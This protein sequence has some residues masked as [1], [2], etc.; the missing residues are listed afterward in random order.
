MMNHIF[1]KARFEQ[2]S[3]FSNVMM[4]GSDIDYF[5]EVADKA[6]I[7]V[8]WKCAGQELPRGQE[9]GFRR[10]VSDLGQVKPSFLVVAEH[11]T[12]PDDAIHG[13]NSK[14]VRV[15]YRLPNMHAPG[16]YL[17]DGQLPSLNQ[18]LSD[19]TLE[20]QIPHR[21]NRNTLHPWEG[22][23]GPML[24]SEDEANGYEYLEDIPRMY[25][26][27]SEFFDHLRPVKDA[28]TGA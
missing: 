14:V 17:Y 7:A 4:W 16:Q 27:P 13:D 28:Y 8:E 24:C 9:I 5:S 23:A 3:D 22:Y 26:A 20:F 25:P 2:Q 12:S 11:S 18:W 21:M 19:F 10:L 15:N 6:Y 1:N